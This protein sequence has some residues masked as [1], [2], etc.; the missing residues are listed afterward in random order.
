MA[1]QYQKMSDEEFLRRNITFKESEKPYEPE[2]TSTQELA[3]FLGINMIC[4]V[5][6]MMMMTFCYLSHIVYNNLWKPTMK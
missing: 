1:Q 6:I 5:S 3:R 4:V 2:L